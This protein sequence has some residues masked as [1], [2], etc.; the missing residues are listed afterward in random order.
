MRKK[1]PAN[2]LFTMQHLMI[3]LKLQIDRDGQRVSVRVWK[4]VSKQEKNFLRY[5]VKITII[6][7]F[8]LKKS[9]WMWILVGVS[10]LQCCDRVRCIVLLSRSRSLSTYIFVLFCFQLMKKKIVHPNTWI[11]RFLFF[12]F[13]RSSFV[14]HSQSFS[15]HFF[16]LRFSL[17]FCLSWTDIQSFVLPLLPCIQQTPTCFLMLR[18]SEK[19]NVL[20][21]HIHTET[22]LSGMNANVS[23]SKT[24]WSQ[25][26]ERENARW[27]YL[28]MC[29]ILCVQ[30]FDLFSYLRS[31]FF[32]HFFSTTLTFFR[33]YHNSMYNNS[34]HACMYLCICGL[35]V[36]LCQWLYVCTWSYISW[37]EPHD[38]DD[39]IQHKKHIAKWEK[40]CVHYK[41]YRIDFDIFSDFVR[42]IRSKLIIFI[43]IQCRA[44]TCNNIHETHWTNTECNNICPKK[45]ERIPLKMCLRNKL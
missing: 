18:L 28:N 15:L 17:W 13:I 24:E 19:C 27:S 21:L 23:V 42:F 45:S 10:V 9:L 43:W 25:W 2:S 37:A 3:K 16:H 31:M 26:E 29:G 41:F 11:C 12:L 39:N 40:S 14:V 6:S 34:T 36:S 1:D 38:D 20:S 32:F 33:F 4:R 8:E 5:Y 7:R 22:L 44:K 30:R 35:C